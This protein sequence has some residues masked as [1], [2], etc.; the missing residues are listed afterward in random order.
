MVR[1]AAEQ[2]ILW[3]GLMDVTLRIV[4]RIGKT[5]NQTAKV[6]SGLGR[7]TDRG[8]RTA[9]TTAAHLFFIKRS[10]QPYSWRKTDK[11]L[12]LRLTLPS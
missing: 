5:G 3:I 9:K 10:R 11:Y 12:P 8:V 1:T 6:D 7:F 4:G 2:R